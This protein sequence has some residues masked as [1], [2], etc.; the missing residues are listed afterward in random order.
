[1][2]SSQPPAM[3]FFIYQYTKISAILSTKEITVTITAFSTQLSK[4][5]INGSVK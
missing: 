4:D 2:S 1:M 5:P 3:S